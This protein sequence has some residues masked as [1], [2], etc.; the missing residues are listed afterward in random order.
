VFSDAD[1]A[2]DVKTRR[3][4]TGWVLVLL[5]RAAI[6]WGSKLQPVVAKCT[7]VAKTIAA[8]TATDEAVYCQMLLRGIETLVEPMTLRVDNQATL[9]SMNNEIEDGL[10][11]YLATRVA[12]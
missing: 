5:H 10:T 8:P 1:R 6:A 12:R 4:T 3:S 9:K 7:A 2:G 11:R